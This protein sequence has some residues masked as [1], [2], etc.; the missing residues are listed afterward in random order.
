MREVK[1]HIGVGPMWA[2]VLEINT[3]IA[4]IHKLKLAMTTTKESDTQGNYSCEP[5]PAVGVLSAL[6]MTH[7]TESIITFPLLIS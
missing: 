6:H 3:N 2:E 7:N 4:Y 1:Q 5:V